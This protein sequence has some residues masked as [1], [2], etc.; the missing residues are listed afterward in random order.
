MEE[1]PQGS[2]DEHKAFII[3]S[4]CP[5]CQQMEL[6]Q[7]VKGT[8]VFFLYKFGSYNACYSARYLLAV[9]ETVNGGMES[10]LASK[11]TLTL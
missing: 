10:S 6:S 9:L 1:G 7:L 11:R 2:S 8:A 4:S 3:V 5:Y